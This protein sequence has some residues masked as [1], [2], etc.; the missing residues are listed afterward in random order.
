MA[1]RTLLSAEG[2][3]LFTLPLQK[4]HNACQIVHSGQTHWIERETEW[5]LSEVRA[6]F[7]K[8]I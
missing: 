1:L 7:Q 6:E 5:E 8:N 4:N 3:E 2:N